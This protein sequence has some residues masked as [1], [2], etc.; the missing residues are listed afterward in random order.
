M[1]RAGA[2]ASCPAGTVYISG[3]AAC[4]LYLF[5]QGV[6]ALWAAGVPHFAERVWW[7]SFEKRVSLAWLSR[8]HAPLH[9]RIP[10]TDPVL[11]WRRRHHVH[12][13]QGVAECSAL[14]PTPQR[15][16]GRCAVDTCRVGITALETAKRAHV[17][18]QYWGQMMC[19]T[20]LLIIH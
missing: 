14:G 11:K 8:M 2:T 17:Q 16:A 12:C 18:A 9:R 15:L 5:V 10:A 3:I 1:W 13:L 7:W 4:T 6:V 19:N 20:A